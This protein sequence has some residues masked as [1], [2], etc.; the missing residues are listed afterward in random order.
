M[1]AAT[2]KKKPAA[3]VETK[4]YKGF[5]AGVFSGIAKLS[6]SSFGYARRVHLEKS[7]CLANK[8]HIYSRP[9]L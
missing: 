5:V 4:N 7:C 2:L 8:T 3:P 1:M 6:G 9:S